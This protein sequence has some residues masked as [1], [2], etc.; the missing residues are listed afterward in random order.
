MLKARL[1]DGR[2]FYFDD[3]RVKL[4]ARLAALSQLTFHEGL[5][6]YQEKQER[7]VVAARALA[8]ALGLEARLAVCLERA[9]ELCK[10]DLVTNLVRE[11]P[12]LQGYVG[13]WYAYA[14]G[15]P[16]DV[17]AAIASHYAPRFTDDDIPADT[18]GCLASVVD[19]L[20][21]LVGLFALG[22]RPS[23]SSDP[24]VLRRQAQGLIDILIDGLSQYR[25][26]LTA[27]MGQLLSL[28]EPKLKPGGEP[29]K[30]GVRELGEFLVQRLRAKLLERGF[31]RELV[32]SVL[33]AGDPLSNLPDLLVRLESLQEMVRSAG[34]L[35]LVRAGV[36]VG[37]ILTADSPTQLDEEL[38][39]EE[40][41]IALWEAFKRDV[42]SAW[43]DDGSFRPPASKEEYLRLLCLLSKVGPLVDQLFDRVMIND[44]DPVKRGN[45]HALLSKLDRY[46]RSV[47][48]FPRLQP[49]LP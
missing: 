35:D 15:E 13:S 45:R 17:V 25:V 36:R 38:L 31:G 18:V 26:N 12:E 40:A 5:G 46:F 3:Q 24:Y 32:E 34:G 21:N 19:K 4:S 28:L 10:L 30:K 1:A 2:F 27:L 7:L 39:K 37:N 44:P 49:L 20:D 47:A 33:N 42:L 8:E 41:E 6:S 43:E 29:A 14:D 16:P 48:D 23:G 22:K 11:L 9:L